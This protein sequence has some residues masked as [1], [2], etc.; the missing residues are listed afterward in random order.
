MKKEVAQLVAQIDHIPGVEVRS[1]GKAH[2]HVYLDE[3]LVTTFPRTPS[4]GRWRAN[5]VADL[6]RAGI[7]PAVRPKGRPQEAR[8]LMAIDELRARVASFPRSAFGRFLADDM[9]AIDPR[10][11]TYKTPESAAVAMKSLIDGGGLTAKAHLLLDSAVRAWD[12]RQSRGTL[13]TELVEREAGPGRL[14]GDLTRSDPALPTTES[15]QPTVTLRF[16]LDDLTALARRFGIE[17]EVE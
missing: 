14:P 4:D 15:S 16:R 1:N 5:A 6:R 17:L 7:T 12:H 9:H 13:E 3:R 2:L 8:E 11:W 10:L